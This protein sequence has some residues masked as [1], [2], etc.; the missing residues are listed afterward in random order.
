MP[1][2]KIA[3]ASDHAGFDLKETLKQDIATLGYEAIDLGP[4]DTQ[5][6]DYPD[7]A[8]KLAE[9]M[10]T[11]PLAIGVLICGSGIGMSMAA[12]RHKHIRAALVH[13][14]VEAK[15]SRQHNNANVLCLGAR[16]IGSEIA[17]DCLTQFI[18]TTFEGGRHEARVAKFSC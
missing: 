18:T 2:G 6:V 14:G 13:T 5:S 1:T 15:L 11:Q 7:F 16:I 9:W 17:R 12:N 3:I 10:K 4:T 8:A